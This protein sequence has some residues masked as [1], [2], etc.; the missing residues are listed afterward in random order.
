MADLCE[1]D[2]YYHCVQAYSDKIYLC[3][4]V[5]FLEK[6]TKQKKKRGSGEDG[7]VIGSVP[8]FNG[9][10]LEQFW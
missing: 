1:K 9:T 8:F 2:E 6:C 4:G 3:T 5:C 7:L 10:R